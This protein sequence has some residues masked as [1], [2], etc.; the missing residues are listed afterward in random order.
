[1]ILGKKPL[2][3][4]LKREGHSPTRTAPGSY[5]IRK[6]QHHKNIDMHMNKMKKKKKKISVCKIQKTPTPNKE[7]T[8]D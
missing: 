3:L 5:N 7:A 1:M 2:G 4:S 6:K 8:R